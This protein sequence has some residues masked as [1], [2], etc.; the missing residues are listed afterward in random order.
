MEDSPELAQLRQL[1]EEF[2]AA[3]KE[4]FMERME[5]EAKFASRFAEVFAQRAAIV[6]GAAQKQLDA[7]KEDIEEIEGG[8]R[9]VEKFWLTAMSNHPAVS[10][11]IQAFDVEALSYLT[12]VRISALPAR[13]P[14]EDEGEEEEEE[15]TPFGFKLEFCFGANPFFTNETLSRTF[16]VPTLYMSGEGRIPICEHTEG[17]E[18][19]WKSDDVNLL[20]KTGPQVSVGSEVLNLTPPSFFQFFQPPYLA[21][22]KGKVGEEEAHEIEE[23]IE[24]DLRLALH[25]YHA[26]V[27]DAVDWFTG[28]A[29]YDYDFYDGEDDEEGEHE[30]GDEDDDEDEQEEEEEEQ[31]E[32]PKPRGRAPRGGN[33]KSGEQDCKQQ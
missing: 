26:I 11:T 15:R 19:A 7:D 32:Q 24:M 21:T 13:E 30:E 25:F 8:V 22:I 20:K 31:E 9:G 18:V 29:V 4:M 2:E 28:D 6:A 33:K 1:H 5:L 23:L 14:N 17:S 10:N 12:D 16:A 3:Q 27:P